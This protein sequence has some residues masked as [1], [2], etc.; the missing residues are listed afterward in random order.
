MRKFGIFVPGQAVYIGSSV[1]LIRG[2]LRCTES[3][4]ACSSNRDERVA[5]TS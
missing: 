2:G 4:T 5:L 3:N 1:L